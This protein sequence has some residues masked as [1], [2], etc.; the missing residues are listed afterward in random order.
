LKLGTLQRSMIIV[1]D[2]VFER[3]RDYHGWI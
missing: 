2:N 1:I 3:M